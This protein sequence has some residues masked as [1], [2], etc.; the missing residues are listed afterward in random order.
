M[1]SGL[2][3]FE[4]A[5]GVKAEQLENFP[6]VDWSSCAS[7]PMTPGKLLFSLFRTACSLSLHPIALF[8]PVAVRGNLHPIQKVA[9]QYPMSGMARL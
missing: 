1:F 2:D 9:K 4:G 3:G 5:E 7:P 8:F 6:N